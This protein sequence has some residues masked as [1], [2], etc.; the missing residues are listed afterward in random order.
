MSYRK[1]SKRQKKNVLY[2]ED[3]QAQDTVRY[4]YVEKTQP[5]GK[6]KDKMVAGYA[7]TPR[8]S[9]PIPKHHT[10]DDGQTGDYTVGLD[11]DNWPGQ[12]PESSDKP[13][14]REKKVSVCRSCL[15]MLINLRVP[16]T[17]ALYRPIRYSST[18]TITIS[19]D[20]RGVG[21]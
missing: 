15:L 10:D 6:A 20:S 11:S 21:Q 17:S 12:N 7:E 19:A 2:V 4:T 13:P 1:P 14:P 5:G 3:I 9:Q 16:D 18:I 8:Q